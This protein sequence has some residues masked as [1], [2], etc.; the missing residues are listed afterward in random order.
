M[1]REK[2]ASKKL[3]Y[4]IFIQNVR[5]ANRENTWTTNV[6]TMKYSTLS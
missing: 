1:S 5:D 2:Q 6:Q 3:V 4:P